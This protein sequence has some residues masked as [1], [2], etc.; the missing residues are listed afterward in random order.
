MK[1]KCKKD[2]WNEAGA[3]DKL[4]AAHGAYGNAEITGQ[5]NAK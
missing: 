4:I 5:A 3:H 2:V 1:V